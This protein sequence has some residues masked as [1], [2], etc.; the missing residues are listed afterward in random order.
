[1]RLA[2]VTTVLVVVT[3]L[4]LDLVP[5]RGGAPLNTGFDLDGDR[6]SGGNWWQEP[7]QIPAAFADAP[8]YPAY[9]Q[10]IEWITNQAVAFRPIH[11]DRVADV[12]TRTVNVVDGVRRT[13]R[14]P[15]CSCRRRTVWMY[16][17]STTFGLGQ[18][19]DHT[20]ASE[21][22][23]IAW[24]DGIALD[25]VNR[26]VPG[27]LHWQE[28]TRFAWDLQSGPTP[29]LV[30]FY[31]GVNEIWATGELLSAGRGDIDRPAEPLIDQVWKGVL[32][33]T[34]SNP[35]PAPPGAGVPTSSSLPVPGPAEIGRT[36]VER[37]GRSLGMSRDLVEANG[38]VAHWFWQPSRLS[39][40]P[41]EGEPTNG[42]GEA[43][44]RATTEAAEAAI[45]AGVHDLTD[46][47]DA[48]PGP[49]FSDD[50]HHNEVG[51]RLVAEAIYQRIRADLDAP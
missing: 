42:D 11:R 4:A 28:A 33:N 25:V 26:G 23:R 3:A 47:F 38:L 27:D 46:V 19:D 5:D 44:A 24:R 40:P 2:V 36:A 13:W 9:R 34:D 29:D 16:G 1:V 31:D 37:Y 48:F 6:P 12:R 14:P 20:I 18:R 10:D 21:L 7:D 22:A 49:L 39:R 8:W 50:V 51:A 32:D 35:P 30:L 17:G 15:Q 43:R 45:P 41:V